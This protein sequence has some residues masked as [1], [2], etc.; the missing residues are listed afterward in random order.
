MVA[1]PS[2]DAAVGFDE[3]VGVIGVAVGVEVGQERV[4]P[5]CEG[6]AGPCGF[7]DGAGREAGDDLLSELA[8]L[9][10]VRVGVGGPDVWRTGMRCGPLGGGRR[11]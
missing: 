8:A 11:C 6:A 3:P 9:A 1:G 7:G 10:G 5:V 4:L 2:G